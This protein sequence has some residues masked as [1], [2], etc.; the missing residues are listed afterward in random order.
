MIVHTYLAGYS[1]F[2]PDLALIMMR[3]GKIRPC[4]L[5]HEFIRVVSDAQICCTQAQGVKR[6][7]CQP[8]LPD[9]S[10]ML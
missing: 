10:V 8:M 4:P 1:T 6:V 3:K 5:L 7:L 9:Y 2:I